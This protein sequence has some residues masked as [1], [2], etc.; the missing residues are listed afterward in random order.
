MSQRLT[1]DLGS[2]MSDSYVHHTRVPLGIH[3]WGINEYVNQPLLARKPTSYNH[4]FLASYKPNTTRYI[5]AILSDRL[6]QVGD[7]YTR[8]NGLTE[9]VNRKLERLLIDLTF[10]SSRLEGVTTSYV[11]TAELIQRSEEIRDR[12]ESSDAIMILNHKTAIQFILTCRDKHFDAMPISFNLPSLRQVHTS[13]MQGLHTDVEIG[14]TRQRAV[15]IE[16]SAYQPLDI[17]QVLND[18]LSEIL[19]KC[20]EISD[21]F[22]QSFFA[23]V[24]I[25]YLQPFA[26][27][28]KRTSR[29]MAN[30]PLLKADL[31]PI[32]FLATSKL[33][34]TAAMLGIYELNRI[35]MLRDVF[36]STYEQ[37]ASRIHEDKDRQVAPTLLELQNRKSINNLVEYVFLR[38]GT[39]GDIEELK[40]QINEISDLTVEEQ[41]DLLSVVIETARVTT[42]TS[43][44]PYSVTEAEFN[45]WEIRRPFYL[46]SEELPQL[47]PVSQI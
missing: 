46:N 41:Q 21:P 19:E 45:S 39:G 40:E 47:R 20:E 37:T 33:A 10:G 44:F 11:A 42:S 3:S 14:V 43:Y 17:P 1:R 28:N 7:M 27:G 8:N 16:G 22:E 24:H 13:L 12:Q 18:Y 34:Y 36:I 25:P 31:C 30:I 38:V 23:L 32:S 2:A 9:D 26:D 5:P 35:E 4:R 29:V 6:A 15:A